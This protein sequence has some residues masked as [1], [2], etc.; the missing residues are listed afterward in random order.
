MMQFKNLKKVKILSIVHLDHYTIGMTTAT[1]LI[2]LTVES[3]TC[4]NNNYFN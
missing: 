4:E 1:S 2:D 3:F